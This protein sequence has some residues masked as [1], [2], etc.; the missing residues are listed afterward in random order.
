MKAIYSLLILLALPIRL[1]AYQEAPVGPAAK[2]DWWQFNSINTQFHALI[3]LFAF[4]GVLYFVW[5]A[6]GE[7]SGNKKAVKLMSALALFLVFLAVGFSQ[8]N[9]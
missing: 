2:M 3:M 7:N 5:Q 6:L 8:L 1:T 4:L 9:Q